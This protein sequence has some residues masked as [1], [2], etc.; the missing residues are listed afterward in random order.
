MKLFIHLSEIIGLV[1]EN[2]SVCRFIPLKLVLES[3]RIG[4]CII[5]SHV[6]TQ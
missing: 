2:L 6:K 4:A 1:N 3:K 5:N